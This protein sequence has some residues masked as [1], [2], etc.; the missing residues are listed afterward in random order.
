MISASRTQ[1]RILVLGASGMLGNAVMGVFLKGGQ[2]VWGTIRRGSAGRFPEAVR[3]WIVP[4]VDIENQDTLLKVVGDLRPDVVINC[5]GLIKQLAEADDPL[6]VLPINAI[7]PHRLAR[8]CA[9][10][11]ARLIHVST[12]CVFDGA[13]GGYRETDAPTAKDLYGRSKLLGEVDYPNAITLRT[14]IIGRELGSA[15]GLLDWFLAQDHGIRGFR[16]AIFSG[17][18]TVELALV[19]RD[20]VVPAPNLR[21]IYHVSVDP[22]SKFDLLVL[23]AEVFGRD[24]RIDPDESIVIDRSLNSDRFRAATG[25]RPPAWRDLLVQLRD[26]GTS[27]TDDA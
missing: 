12:D 3:D 24:I 25:Y 18:T 7:L 17:L 4:G 27:G 19:M 15:N 8:L 13:A 22:I 9:A 16:R 23:A 2:Q 26:F 20:L 1:P 10:A 5:V 21:G 11:G 14:S 6:A